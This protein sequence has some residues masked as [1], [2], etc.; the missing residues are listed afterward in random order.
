M[1]TSLFAQTRLLPDVGSTL[2]ERFGRVPAP[3]V[4]PRVVMGPDELVR[5]RQVMQQTEVGKYTLGRVDHYVEVLHTGQ[6]LGAEFDGLVKGDLNATTYVKDGFWQNKIVY[7]LSL[8]CFEALLRQD[9]VRG[10]QAAAA[11]ATYA[12]IPRN[13]A[14]IDPDVHL[15]LAY[16]FDYVYMTDVQRR[17]VRQAISLSTVGKKVFGDGMPADWNTSNWMPGGMGL[18]LSALAIEGEQGYDAAIYPSC[19]QVMKNF[20]HYGITQAGGSI[21]EMHYFHY[22]MSVGALALVAF[23]RHGDDLFIEP[24]YRALPNWLVAAMEPYG[25]AFSMHQD[26]PNDQGGVLTNYLILKWLWPKDP[27]VDMIW[28]N[29]VETDPMAGLGNY[30]DWLFVLLF[31]SDPVGWKPYSGP[32]PHTKWGLNEAA[33]PANYPD[34]VSGIEALNLPLTYWDPER[35]LQITRNKW[36][37]DGM[38]LHLDMNTQANYAAA[39]AHSNS[40]E[41]TLSALGRKWAI[42]RGFHV[43]ETKD[44]SC[45]L[46]DGRGQGF[47]PIGGATVERREEPN[48]T[49]MA[50]DASEPYHWILRAQIRL[51]DPAIS[52]FHW[53]PDTRADVV[54]RFDEYALVMN[55]AEPWHDR[56]ATQYTFHAVYNPVEKAFRTAALRRNG[57]HDYALIVDDINKDGSSHQYDWLMQV[58]DDLEVKSTN[59]NSMVLGSADAKDNRRLLVQMIGVSGGGSWVF[60]KYE[61]KRTPESGDTAS[62]GMGNRLRYSVRGVEPGFKVLLYP[63]REGEALPEVSANGLLELRWA[64]QKDDYVLTM[65]PTGRTEVRMR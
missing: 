4:H 50:G 62:F 21:E 26:T 60:E 43:A 29:R 52:A 5:L 40:G 41:F 10:Q 61:V 12:S 14:K 27:V 31:P 22:G 32:N 37:R 45:I 49:V 1:Q 30:G 44:S 20:L 18:V 15:A 38:V 16:D 56:Q 51:N 58:A 53:E 34:A 57:S 59:G 42:D 64:N 46:I 63:Y 54:R 28:R 7:V 48:L 17:V 25:D 3:G 19:R 9:Q 11:L 33:I 36:G 47:F 35:G 65:L 6:P 24:H 8:E 2:V 13:W 39:H 23:A 55:K